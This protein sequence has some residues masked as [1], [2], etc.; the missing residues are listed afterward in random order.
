MFLSFFQPDLDVFD[1]ADL[2]AQKD[3]RRTHLQPLGRLVKIQDVL[4]PLLKPRISGEKQ[5]GDDP[6]YEGAE[7]KGADQGGIGLLAHASPLVRK[8]RTMGSP[9]CI[10]SFGLPVA[11]MVWVSASR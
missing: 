6:E 7:N 9:E 10:A 1:R 4:L 8:W 3:H 11:I 5:D 2:D